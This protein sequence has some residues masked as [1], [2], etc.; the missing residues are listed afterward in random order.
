MAREPTPL[1]PRP[2][3]RRLRIAMIAPPWF[4]LPPRGYGGIE[5]VVAALVDQL[6]LRGHEVTLVGAGRHRTRASRFVAVYDV[7]PSERLGSPVPEVVQAAGAAEALEGAAVDVVHDHTLAGPLTAR[8]R[9][10]PTLLTM[11]GPATG[12]LARYVRLLGE[13]VEVVAI[14]DSQRRLEPRLNW[15]A[16]VHNAVDVPTFP[17]RADKD[18]YVLWLGRFC[19]DK[20][21]CEA[22]RAARAAGRPLLLAGKCSEPAERAYFDRHVRPLLG[23]GAEYLGEVDGATKRELLSRAACLLFPIQWEEPFG[24]VM[25]E[26]LACGTPVV[27][28]AR[29]SV[30]E[31]VRHRITGLVVADEAALP[32]ALHRIDA[33]DPV[34]C[35]T[36][37][38]V[39][40]DL[41][42]MAAGYEGV[43]QMLTDGRVLLDALDQQGAPAVA[44]SEAG[45]HSRGRA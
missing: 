9:A 34:A 35:R 8:G 1:P 16:T 37:A 25:V 18:R 32:A 5:A 29:G 33:V 45:P 6:S 42:V 11:H 13:T 44:G 10:A 24:M 30:P 3:G 22:I 28:L 21:P 17:F 39:R 40:F 43:Y 27:A 14:S 4:D 31:V 15:V 19:A 7:P 38:E 23:R 26:A 20:G 2:R 36:D 12:E 41:P